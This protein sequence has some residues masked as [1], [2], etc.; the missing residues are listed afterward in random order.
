MKLFNTIA[1]T[2]LLYSSGFS[3]NYL[4][5][6]GLGYSVI[7]LNPYKEQLYS[8]QSTLE[9]VKTKLAIGYLFNFSVSRSL[10]E[11][12]SI[13]FGVNIFSGKS[14]SRNWVGIIDNIKRETILTASG[15]NI[16]PSIRLRTKYK[17]LYPFMKYGFTLNFLDVTE[18]IT[19]ESPRSNLDSESIYSGGLNF[20]LS[21]S[22]GTLYELGNNLSLVPELKCNVLEFSPTS[23]TETNNGSKKEYTLK[24]KVDYSIKYEKIAKYFPLNSLSIHLSLAY[25][26]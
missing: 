3:Q 11:N 14:N 16:E 7:D 19:A 1:L 10:T 12:V 21:F 23:V 22:V 8:T 15:F 24:D 26:L 2:L 4:I 18:K 20:G 9:N 6:G 25:G 17:N 5:S 13:D